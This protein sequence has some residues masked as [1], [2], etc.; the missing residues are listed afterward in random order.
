M[1]LHYMCISG[2]QVPCTTA[3]VRLVRH[4]IRDLLRAD[5]IR[6]WSHPLG[7]ESYMLLMLTTVNMR[8][9]HSK[10]MPTS[11]FDKPFFLPDADDG[12][13]QREWKLWLC[14]WF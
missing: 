12:S 5:D 9:P 7:K 8:F 14:R 1:K 13:L 4:S 6:N 2:S 11:R 10:G 3:V